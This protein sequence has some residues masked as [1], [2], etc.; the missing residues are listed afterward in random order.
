[1]DSELVSRL[2][3]DLLDKSGLDW[4]C[5]ER[6]WDDTGMPHVRLA[7]A[8]PARLELADRPTSAAAT[9]AIAAVFLRIIVCSCLG[10]P[11]EENW[12][13]IRMCADFSRWVRY[14]AVH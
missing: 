2:L 11:R 14:L 10:S 3:Y 12:A 9:L 5:T 7:A 6:K 1:M 13:C 8:K 4:P